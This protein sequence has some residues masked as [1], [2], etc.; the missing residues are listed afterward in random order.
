MDQTTRPTRKPSRRAE[1]HDPAAL[2]SGCTTLPLKGSR[3]PGQGA[4]GTVES[5][6]AV[7]DVAGRDGVQTKPL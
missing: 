5:L 1:I 2:H 6:V 7:G 3:I 4:D